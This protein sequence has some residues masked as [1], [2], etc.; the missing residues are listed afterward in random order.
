MS[1]T[2]KSI[3]PKKDSSEAM[4]PPPRPTPKSKVSASVRVDTQEDKDKAVRSY[5]KAFDQAEA[6][7]NEVVKAVGSKIPASVKAL[8]NSLVRSFIH[9]SF[10][11]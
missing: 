3:R 2:R 7:K 8:G 5:Q 11:C 1:S 6:C 9:I 4:P 10:L